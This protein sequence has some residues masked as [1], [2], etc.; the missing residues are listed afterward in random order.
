MSTIYISWVVIALEAEACVF[1]CFKGNKHTENQETYKIT[2]EFKEGGL[3][4]HKMYGEVCKYMTTYTIFDECH[5]S[6]QRFIIR[7][8]KIKTQS[9]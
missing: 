8:H 9:S 6:D 2:T 7:V 3:E 5:H 1:Q 4:A